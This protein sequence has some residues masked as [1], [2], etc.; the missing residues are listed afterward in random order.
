MNIAN[1]M[2]R[3]GLAHSERPAVALGDAVLLTYQAL[4][5]RVARIAGGLAFAWVSSPA[6]GWP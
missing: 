2:V 1:H 6:T 3:A 4:A 5:E